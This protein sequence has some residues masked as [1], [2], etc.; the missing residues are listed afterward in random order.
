[1]QHGLITPSGDQSTGILWFA[2]STNFSTGATGIDI[3][4]GTENT[5]KII[6]SQGAGSYDAQFFNDF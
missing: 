5:F 1:V 4:T 3:G 2:G 6:T